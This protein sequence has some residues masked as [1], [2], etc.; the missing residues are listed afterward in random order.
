MELL[1]PSASSRSQRV[2]DSCRSAFCD[3]R[4]ASTSGTPLR[5]CERL[6]LA[7]TA[8]ST[9]F[10]IGQTL[11]GAIAPL[12]PLHDH[13]T[14]S[15]YAS[16][17]QEGQTSLAPKRFTVYSDRLDQLVSGYPVAATTNDRHECSQRITLRRKAV[18]TFICQHYL[19]VFRSRQPVAI[20]YKQFD[21][22]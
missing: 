4:A 15:W 18:G 8:R 20:P 2:C 13:I 14:P 5:R 21:A 19:S 22:F 7:S 11:A 12:T 17:G 10:R 16:P 6:V 3:N 9:L 1:S